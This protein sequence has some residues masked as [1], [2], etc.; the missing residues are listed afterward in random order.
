MTSDSKSVRLEELDGI[1]I[2]L[3]AIVGELAA[4]EQEKAQAVSLYRHRQ[5]EACI[6]REQASILKL[7][8]AEE[9]R[10]ECMK[11]LGWEGL[12]LSQ[13]TS[14]LKEEPFP[15]LT[16]SL[17]RLKEATDSLL[18]FKADSERILKVRLHAL[19]A[20]ADQARAEISRKPS[21]GRTYV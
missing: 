21:R 7:R 15:R 16:A 20:A 17:E 18:A 3:T 11:A 1:I 13:L 12:S 19:E 8:G 14:A 4:I 2:K 9:K 6:R 5:L 10:L